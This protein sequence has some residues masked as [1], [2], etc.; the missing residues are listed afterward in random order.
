[1][2]NLYVYTEY[3]TEFKKKYKSRNGEAFFCKKSVS[4]SEL[5][6]D[7]IYIFLIIQICYDNP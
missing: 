6:L 5:T 4:L 1:M 3:Y 2:F 7:F